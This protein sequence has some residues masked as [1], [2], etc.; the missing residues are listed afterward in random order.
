MKVRAR[1]INRPCS[2]FAYLVKRFNLA[3][4]RAVLGRANS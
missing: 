4:A 1:A 2:I 3:A